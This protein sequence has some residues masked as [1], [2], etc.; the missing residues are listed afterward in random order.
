MPVITNH[1]SRNSVIK[2]VQDLSGE[3]MPIPEVINRGMVLPRPKKFSL[4]AGV[5]EGKT[6]LTA[7]DKALLA[8]G[9]GNINLIKLSSI[10][11]PNVSL[12]EISRYP[13][14]LSCAYRRT[15]QL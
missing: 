9:I 10:L 14:R 12:P 11:P 8:A 6:R 5:S 7:F 3:K 1:F 15:V 2:Q 4:V 13:S